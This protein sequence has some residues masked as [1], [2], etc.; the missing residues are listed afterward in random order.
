MNDG[1]DVRTISVPSSTKGEGEGGEGKG[2]KGRGRKGEGEGSTFVIEFRSNVKS[3]R[4]EGYFTLNFM[5]N[6]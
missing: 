3:G 1:D 4:T 2:R 5:V 6:E